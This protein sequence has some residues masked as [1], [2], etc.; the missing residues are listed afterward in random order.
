MNGRHVLDGAGQEG[1]GREGRG[2]QEGEQ[3]FCVTHSASRET[4]PL[5][6]LR[7]RSAHRGKT[8]THTHLSN[9]MFCIYTTEP[10]VCKAWYSHYR[11]TLHPV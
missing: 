9:H 3:C 6:I 1:R 5:V 7:W 4:V 11:K 10:T 2:G 8:H